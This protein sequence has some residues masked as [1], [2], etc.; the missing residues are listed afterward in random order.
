MS[1]KGSKIQYI[2]TNCQ[3]TSTQWQG[4]CQQCNEWNTLVESTTASGLTT[5][6]KTNV[7]LRASEQATLADTLKNLDE[8]PIARHQFHSEQLNDFF[9][10]GLA[11]DSITLL[12]G[13]PGLGKSTLSL[14]LL[15]SLI[16]NT[17][18]SSLY[19]TA[20]ESLSEVAR[21]AHRL[22]VPETLTILQTQQF[23]IIEKELVSKKPSVVILDS[24][25]TVYSRSMD[26]APGSVAQ[27]T[28]IVTQ[29]MAICK[30]LGIALIIIGHVT[31]EGAI[32]GPRTLEHL[33]DTV[34][35]LERTQHD[36]LTLSFSKNRFG[37][38]EHILFLKMQEGGLVIITDPSLLLLENLEDGVGIT[39]S[40]VRIKNQN[41]VVE[42][43]ALTSKNFSG[44]GF[45][46]QGIGITSAKLN[47][48]IA[49][50]KKYLGL[51]LD[52]F[53]IY[54]TLQGLPKG[55]WD[56]S[57]DLAIL[58][59]IISSY[60]NAPIE[61]VLKI[62]KT[63]GRPVFSGRITLS[64]TIRTATAEITRKKTASTLKLQYN[65]AIQ[66]GQLSLLQ[67]Y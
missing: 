34:L 37:T 25:Q 32:A 16:I 56:E 60:K 12:A 67:I 35:M 9:S 4:K 5:T 17:N 63:K 30:T 6:A 40:I 55:S 28:N 3:H 44:T 8:G 26:S 61:D 14:Q 48:L 10:G 21:R 66:A 7:Q 15:K 58:L 23:E 19:I 41:I 33:V 46:R 38:T 27:V 36:L 18:T 51:E 24:I 45:Q 29:L 65:P 59:S 62:T 13:E 64:G 50:L 39:Y 11:P 20:E 49:I 1:K 31:K 47:S 42:V 52:S 2:C 43:Q 22:K 53:D 54:V 57:L